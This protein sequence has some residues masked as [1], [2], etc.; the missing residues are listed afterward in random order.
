LG[1]GFSLNV[2]LLLQHVPIP[3]GLIPQDRQFLTSSPPPPPR[4][5]LFTSLPIAKVSR[6]AC[7]SFRAFHDIL[8]PVLAPPDLRVF[9]CGHIPVPNFPLYLIV[10]PSGPNT[11]LSQRGLTLSL[12]E[13][14]G[15]ST[16]SS[17]HL[18]L[19]AP[20]TFG[21]PRFV[22]LFHRGPLCIAR[23]LLP[24]NFSAVSRTPPF[25]FPPFVFQNLTNTWNL[26]QFPAV[27]F[28]SSVGSVYLQPPYLDFFWDSIYCIPF[29]RLS[30]FFFRGFPQHV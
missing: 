11:E 20:H 30:L 7:S 15:R 2:R 28:R 27:P 17:P 26:R 5:F 29:P 3:H 12:S 23:S 25:I 18:V 13:K 16:C 4:F 14:Q 8:F 6:S 21:F 9:P 10:C 19:P 1:S 24:L 22:P